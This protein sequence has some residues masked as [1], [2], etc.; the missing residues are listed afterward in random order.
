MADA[1]AKEGYNTYD[2]TLEPSYSFPISLRIFIFPLEQPKRYAMWSHEFSFLRT[3]GPSEHRSSR[4]WVASLDFLNRKSA[5]LSPDRVLHT[6]DKR[7]ST[8]TEVFILCFSQNTFFKLLSM[9]SSSN[10]A[11]AVIFLS[12]TCVRHNLQ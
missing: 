7:A 5:S 11:R 12:Q 6:P 10:K 2:T 8:Q 1:Y 3:E 9:T 4:L